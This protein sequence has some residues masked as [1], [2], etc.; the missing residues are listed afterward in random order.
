[1]AS[2]TVSLTIPQYRS[3]PAFNMVSLSHFIDSRT[4]RPSTGNPRDFPGICHKHSLARE[5][6]HAC[7]SNDQKVAQFCHIFHRVYLWLL[8]TLQVALW[9]MLAAQQRLDVFSKNLWR[10]KVD[11]GYLVWH[12]LRFAQCL[13]RNWH[14]REQNGVAKPKLILSTPL[15]ASVPLCFICTFL[16]ALY[17][18]LSYF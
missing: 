5:L 16:F 18:F 1:M 14:E 9:A 10:T 15:L 17:S 7:L 6:L 3:H 4:A 2:M 11:I 13:L 8:S 12:Y